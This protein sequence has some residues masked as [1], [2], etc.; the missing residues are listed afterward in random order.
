MKK[1]ILFMIFVLMMIMPLGVKAAR[2]PCTTKNYS[3]LKSLTY[4]VKLSYELTKNEENQTVFKINISNL[5]EELEVRYGNITINYDPEKPVQEITTVTGGGFKYEVDIY[6][7]EALNRACVGEKIATKSVDVPKYNYY[8]ERDECIDYEKFYL[9]NKW[10]KGNIENEEYFLDELDKY[11]KKN[12][13]EEQD[14][15]EKYN[16]IDRII[17]FYKEHP[18]I[19]ITI[20][21]LIAGAIIFV[22]ARK[23]IRRKNRIK[24]DI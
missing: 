19:S 11:I 22:I 9:C 1:K 15:E 24:L 5:K 8:S 21:V 7:T 23:L 4:D 14:Q 2:I 10:Y 20:T 3:K 16:I 6:V 18:F 17:D 12:Q 13:E